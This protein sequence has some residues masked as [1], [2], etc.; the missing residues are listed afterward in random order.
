MSATDTSHP[1]P[2]DKSGVC[3]L[4]TEG[5]AGIWVEAEHQQKGPDRPRAVL[6]MV[7]MS[8]HKEDKVG[9]RKWEGG[10]RKRCTHFVSMLSL[11]PAGEPSWGLG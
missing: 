6:E 9:R 8:P 7:T 1:R 3:S 10:G 4:S 5:R 2:Q 11:G